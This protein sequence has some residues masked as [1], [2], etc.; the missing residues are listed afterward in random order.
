MRLVIFTLTDG[1]AVWVNPEQV[2]AVVQPRRPLFSCKGALDG[3]TDIWLAGGTHAI[4]VLGRPGDVVINLR[5]PNPAT[6][7]ED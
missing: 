1:R 2:E 4:R 7:G 5:I 6:E 3:M